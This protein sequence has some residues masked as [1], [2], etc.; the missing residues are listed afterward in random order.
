MRLR[1]RML[2]SMAGA[3][4]L[5][6]AVFAGAQAENRL[7]GNYG[8]NNGGGS[9]V[10]CESNDGRR[11]YC[12][13]YGYNQVQFDRQISSSPCIQGQTWGVDNGGLWVDRGC[14]AY[15]NVRRGPGHGGEGHGGGWSPV[16]CESNNGR[17]N[18]CGNYSY[19]QVQF[20]RQISGSPCIQGQTWGVDN[21]GLWVDKGCRAYFNVRGGSGYGNGGPG[22][23]GGGSSLKCESNNGKR[24]YCGSY[25]YNQVRIDK[26]ISG[27]PCI[28]GQSWG[29]DNRGLW[30]DQGC[31]AYFIVSGGGGY[32][33]GGNDNVW[34]HPGP[35]DTWPPRGDW[36][37]GNWGS[38]G[39]CFYKDPNFRGDYFCMRRGEQR[40]NVPGYGDEISSIRLFGGA[41][42]WIFDDRNFGG[43][44]EGI[45]RDVSNLHDLPVRQLPGHSWNN[46]INSLRVN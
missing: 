41:R 45:S 44:N 21:N 35:N 42:V 7:Q 14:R 25:N 32:G 3:V 2:Y 1:A 39:A 30:V 6:A 27:S 37:G 26:Q 40:D 20:D 11:N 19:N 38:G 9:S 4:A 17:R 36:H 43:A 5:T 18:Y 13:N 8:G 10:K 15:F 24:N 31:R 16:K 12:G 34:W 33:P 46:R 22:Y 23:D 28:Q 29:V